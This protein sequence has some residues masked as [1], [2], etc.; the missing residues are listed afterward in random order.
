[1]GKVL[2]AEQ[3]DPN[4][5]PRAHIVEGENRFLQIAL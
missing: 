5:I 3:D 2:A 4:S 1:M